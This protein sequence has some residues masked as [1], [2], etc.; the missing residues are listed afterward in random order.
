MRRWGLTPGMIENEFANQ[1]NCELSKKSRQEPWTGNNKQQV[2]SHTL[3]HLRL[4]E[5]P[6]SGGLLLE[7]PT[8]RPGI[9]IRVP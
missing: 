1:K 4:R 2:K 8:G 9:L 5:A 7:I 3:L 6:H